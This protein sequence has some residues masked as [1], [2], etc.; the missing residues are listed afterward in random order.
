MR[1]VF[2][3]YHHADQMKVKGFDL[4]RYN[5]ALGL[6]F[7]TR[8]LLDPV[9]SLDPAYISRCVKE[10]Q[11][12]TSVTVVLIGEGTAGSD[13]VEKEIRWSLE[14]KPPNGLLGIRLSPDAPVPTGLEGV[15]VLDW[16]RPED[17]REFGPAIE[18]ASLAAR[19]M[20]DA[21][22]QV[23]VDGGNCMR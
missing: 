18:R 5:R 8:G 23:G 2:V 7:T 12:G 4:M 6:E 17:V 1:R 11:R 13:W 10:R 22:L 15:E 16:D 21:L 14:K 20:T 19:R 9:K 3:S